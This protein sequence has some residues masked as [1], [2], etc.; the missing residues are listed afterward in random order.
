MSETKFEDIPPEEP[1]VEPEPDDSAYN[2]DEPE[3][4]EQEF[5]DIEP[6]STEDPIIYRDGTTS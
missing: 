3:P 1:T 6:P 5:P 2:T 4:F